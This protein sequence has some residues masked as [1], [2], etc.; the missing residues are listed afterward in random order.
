[1]KIMLSRFLVVCSIFC[2]AFSFA[3]DGVESFASG[4]P[5][6]VE[7]G[8]TFRVKLST[9]DLNRIAIKGGRISKLWARDGFLVV[10]KAEGEALIL[11]APTSPAVFSFF[12][13]DEFGSTYTLVAERFDIPAQ[14][15]VLDPVKNFSDKQ[16]SGVFNKANSDP[17]KTK[18]N[19]LIKAMALDNDLRGYSKTLYSSVVPL[20]K[21]T[22]ITLVRA[23]EGRAFRGDVYLIE[24]V[25]EGV[26]TFNETEFQ[27]FGDH[28]FGVALSELNIAPGEVSTLFVVRRL[29]EVKHGR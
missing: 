29:P 23:Y 25:S 4:E 27:D 21:E 6:R 18:S 13:R 28:V 11:P 26:L 22:K 15:I 17:I 20:W 2:S 14:S 8:D 5:I 16:V 7:D 24:N 12:V 10:Q 9:R 19:R 3:T 1:M